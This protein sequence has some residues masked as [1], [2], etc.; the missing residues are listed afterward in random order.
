MDR[1]DT[2]IDTRHIADR[3]VEAITDGFHRY[4]Y[5]TDASTDERIWEAV[6]E[7]LESAELT[8]LS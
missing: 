7:E 8:Y 1:K 3:A 2:N 5:V 4:G 6:M